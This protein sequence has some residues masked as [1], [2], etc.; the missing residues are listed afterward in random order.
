MHLAEQVHHL[1]AVRGV[2]V[3]R[4]F[5]GKDELW[6]RHDCPCDGDALLLSAGELGREMLAA[7]RHGQA[8]EHLHHALL[9]FPCRQ[10]HVE[11]RQLDILI[12]AELV[13]EVEAL[14]HEAD[15]ASAQF[16]ALRIVELTH[17]TSA[18][19]V[20]SACRHVEQTHYI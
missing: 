6:I 15:G 9:P 2:E 13:D 18:K 16:G 10:P 8:V 17:V 14:K 19:Q 7:V 12:D 3:S 5:V 1:L 11:K 20:G 4:R